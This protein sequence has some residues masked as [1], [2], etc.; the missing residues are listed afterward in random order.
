MTASGTPR[1]RHTRTVGTTVTPTA[2]SPASASVGARTRT[3]SSCAPCKSW[4]RAGV[5][6]PRACRRAPTRPCATGGTGCS[7]V[8]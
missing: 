1:A 7:S 5:P 3:R 8:R 6:S 4:G 2:M